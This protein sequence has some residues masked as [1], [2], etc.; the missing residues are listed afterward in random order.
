MRDAYI[1]LFRLGLAHSAEAWRGDELVGGLYGVSLGAIFFGE[2]MFARAP[3]AS[4]IA[5]V[6]LVSELRRWGIE[7]IDCQ[8]Y[9]DH[10]ARFGA[11]EWPRVRYLRALDRLLR[12]PTHRGRWRYAAG[13]AASG[14]PAAPGSNA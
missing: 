7:L 2:S 3:D 1:R 4:K 11:V 13:P 5:F 10:L 12:R 14:G 8:V 9:T 6:T